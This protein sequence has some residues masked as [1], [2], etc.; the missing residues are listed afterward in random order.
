[1][2]Y[3]FFWLS[4]FFMFLF[5]WLVFRRRKWDQADSSSEAPTAKVIKSDTSANK[6]VDP[7]EAASKIKKNQ[8]CYVA[9]TI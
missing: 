3:V 9:H 7:V 6:S 2:T 8:V 5:G 1:M 4:I